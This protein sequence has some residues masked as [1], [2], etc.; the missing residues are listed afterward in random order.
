MSIQVAITISVEPDGVTLR[1]GVRSLPTLLMLA[2]ENL[3]SSLDAA[4]VAALSATCHEMCT[5]FH[6]VM[7]AATTQYYTARRFCIQINEARIPL[8]P[9]KAGDGVHQRILSANSVT[10]VWRPSIH[11]TAAGAVLG[12]VTCHKADHNHHDL[13]PTLTVDWASTRLDADD[14]HTATSVLPRSRLRCVEFPPQAVELLLSSNPIGDAGLLALAPALPL[15]P[16]LVTL[17]LEDCRIGDAGAATLAR[18]LSACGDA[19]AMQTLRT[20]CLGSNP[21]ADAGCLALATA[22]VDSPRLLSRGGRSRGLAILQLGDTDIGDVGAEALSHALDEGAMPEAV[23]LWLAS[24]R[25]SPVGRA[26]IM[27]AAS[28]RERLRVCW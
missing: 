20:L 24:T 6:G 15:M 13:S 22:M 28:A 1:L 18:A 19:A 16:T 14:M 11:F 27:L 9:S 4:D 17:A 5:T 10:S 21:I 26:R 7:A 3:L 25:V 23:Q 2:P 12:G 8:D